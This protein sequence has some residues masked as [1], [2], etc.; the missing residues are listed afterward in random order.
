MPFRSSQTVGLVLIPLALLLASCSDQSGRSDAAEQVDR[1]I[2]DQ[3]AVRVERHPATKADETADANETTTVAITPVVAP[4][5]EADPDDEL[6]EKIVGTWKQNNTGVR[7]LKVRPDGTATMFIDPDW[8]AK[9]VIGNGLTVQ[10]EWSI[11]DGRV[12]MRSVS[13]EPSTT[14][15]A[16]TTLYGSDRNRA[17]VELSDETFVMLDEDGSL[18]KWTRVDTHPVMPKAIAN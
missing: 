16:V 6:R 14:F 11:K 5:P 2:D 10:I 1:E 12:L 18:S 4:Q 3:P 17:I 8:I 9:A 13:G 15:K 7:W